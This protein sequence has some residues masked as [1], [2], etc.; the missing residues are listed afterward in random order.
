MRRIKSIYAATVDNEK[1]AAL[2]YAQ[3]QAQESSSTKSNNEVLIL[4][5]QT[6]KGKEKI[7]NNNKTNQPNPIANKNLLC[8]LKLPYAYTA[9]GM[10]WYLKMSKYDTT[11]WHIN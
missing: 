3:A 9:H 1:Q 6:W 4:L 10:K 2:A 8:P 7:D 11:N 5:K